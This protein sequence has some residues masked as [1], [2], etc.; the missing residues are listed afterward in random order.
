MRATRL[1]AGISV[2][3]EFP[4][5][6]CEGKEGRGNLTGLDVPGTDID[7]DLCN[8]SCCSSVSEPDELESGGV[9]GWSS[10]SPPRCR[11]ARRLPF[12]SPSDQLSLLESDRSA[13]LGEDDRDPPSASLRGWWL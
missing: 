12:C 4:S 1:G 11:C 10:S 5:V 3:G 6:V 13:F 8:R 2:C 9:T 7:V